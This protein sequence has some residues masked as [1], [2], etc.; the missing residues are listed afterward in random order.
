MG[1]YYT[2]N[3]KVHSCMKVSAIQVEGLIGKQLLSWMPC[4]CYKQ[5]K[6]A[7]NASKYTRLKSEVQLNLS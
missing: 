3:V 7:K 5:W 1:H 4:I 6:T 2:E